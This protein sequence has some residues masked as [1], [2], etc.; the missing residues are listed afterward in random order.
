MQP[1]QLIVTQAHCA[2]QSAPTDNPINKRLPIVRSIAHGTI[3]PQ[4]TLI[5]RPSFPTPFPFHIPTR[6]RLSLNPSVFQSAL[7][8]WLPRVEKPSEQYD[9]TSVYEFKPTK[10]SILPFYCCG[11]IDSCCC[12]CCGIGSSSSGKIKRSSHRYSNPL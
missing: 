4:C 10:Q 12:Y 6:I 8:Q 9:P 2:P 5:F 11:S 1:G 3:V 7:N